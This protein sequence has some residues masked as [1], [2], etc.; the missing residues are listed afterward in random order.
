MRP[1][2]ILA[3]CESIRR[4]LI[5]A[6]PDWASYL[7]GA[8]FRTSRRLVASAGIASGSRVTISA[9]YYAE[10]VNADTLTNTVKHELAHV[11]ASCTQIQRGLRR[12]GPHGRTWQG[13]MRAMGL[14]P[15]V[16][17]AMARPGTVE[18]PCAVCK[19]PL[20][21]SKRQHTKHASLQRM[22]GPSY[23]YRHKAC[24]EPVRTGPP[25]PSA[26][27]RIEAAGCVVDADG[28]GR[29]EVYHPRDCGN[30]SICATLEE[31]A[32]EAESMV[33]P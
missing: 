22:L 27:E 15:V 24:A 23:G 14:Q 19:L 31:A 32:N 2:E 10:A 25:Q 1:T 7:R 8:S 4:E 3:R 16:C 12:D 26:R 9:A 13:V 11:V 5:D 28:C 21:L 17:H 6:H 33:R 20:K 29:W 18:G 30:V